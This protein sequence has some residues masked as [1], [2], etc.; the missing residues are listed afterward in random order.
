MMNKVSREIIDAEE[1]MELMTAIQ[2]MNIN[3]IVKSIMSIEVL[4]SKLRLADPD[5]ERVTATELVNKFT[6]ICTIISTS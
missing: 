2:T 3:A 1:Y 6:A 5:G 4:N